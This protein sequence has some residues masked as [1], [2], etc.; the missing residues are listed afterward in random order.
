MLAAAPRLAS[1]PALALL[2]SVASAAAAPD[3]LPAPTGEVLMI[4]PLK[5]RMLPL[6][7]LSAEEVA[8]WHGDRF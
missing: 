8:F 2:L 3:G 6:P 7:P 4:R 1:G 5:D